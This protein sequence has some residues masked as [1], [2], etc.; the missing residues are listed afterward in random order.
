M[1]FLKKGS[2]VNALGKLARL[3]KAALLARRTRVRWPKSAEMYRMYF[4][5]HSIAPPQTY[6]KFITEFCPKKVGKYKLKMQKSGAEAQIML[7][8]MGKGRKKVQK[9]LGDEA[10]ILGM[11]LKLPKRLAEYEV[12]VQTNL[13]KVKFALTTAIEPN[14]PHPLDRKRP[15]AVCAV[16]G[17]QGPSSKKYSKPLEYSKEATKVLKEPWQNFL[18]KEIVEHAR[19]QG[20][21]AVA[22]LRPEHNPYLTKKHFVEEGVDPKTIPSIKSQFFAAARKAGLKKV[23]GSKY[24]WVFF[25]ENKT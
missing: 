23:K 8:M 5:I 24:F 6:R 9:M 21:Q 11:K 14:L 10:K 22:L 19:V 17:L 13:F 16:I 2:K 20:M 18:L 7:S 4:D 15:A 25:P 1:I 12:R 3:P